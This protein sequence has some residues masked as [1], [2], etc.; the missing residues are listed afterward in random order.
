MNEEKEYLNYV[1]CEYEKQIEDNKVKRQVVM[2]KYSHDNEAMIS[3]LNNIDQRLKSLTHN[4]NKPFFARIDFKNSSTALV[5]KCYI[6]RIGIMNDDNDIVTIDWRAPIASVYYDCQLGNCTY[7]SPEGLIEGELLIKRQYEIENKR[8]IKFYDVDIVSND[9]LLNE[10]LST[11]SDLRLKN[12]IST[13]QKEQNDIIRMPIEKNIVVQGVAGSGKTTV[14]LHRLAYLVYKNRDKINDDQ[15]M[16]ICPN[17]FF[18]KYI[19]NVLPDLDV[20]GIM[21][22]DLLEFANYF[23]GEKINLFNEKDTEI[24]KY[25][26]SMEYKELIDKYILE[27]NDSVLPDKDLEMFGISII[28]KHVINEIYK[29][30]EKETKFI[31]ARVDRTIMFTKKY[32]TENKDDILV[33][34]D[35]IISD[36]YNNNIELSKNLTNIRNEIKS[37][38]RHILKKYF[39]V[40]NQKIST[41]YLKFLN[42]QSF[43]DK[44]LKYEDLPGLLY[45]GYNIL[46]NAKCMKYEHIVI[47]EAQD[48]GM[49]LF[50][51]MKQIFENSTFSIFGDLAQTIYKYRSIESWDNIK[52]V[53]IENDILFLKKSYRTT[54][55]IM[56]KANIINK[57]LGL[58][59]A[60]SVIRHGEEIEIANNNNILSI[61][62]DLSKKYATIGIISKNYEDSKKIY[63]EL[64]ENVNINLIET[65]SLE[66]NDGI[67]SITSDLAKGLEFDAVVINKCDE[68]I[69]NINDEYDMKLLYVSM[70]RALHKLVITYDKKI[71]SLIDNRRVYE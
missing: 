52:K 11:S 1:L 34:I 59:L 26:S 25:K 32:I 31:N 27:L 55:E 22:V 57:Y 51:S 48:Y 39:N 8:L 5:D 41:L 28:S 58:T 37:D 68:D 21:E 71:V 12:I 2:K 54:I 36:K 7:M 18:V 49:L 70:T 65:N 62:K 24:T 14:A 38:C 46:G 10:S 66:Y 64:K 42:Q 23:L 19:S 13:I 47:D 33:K 30:V 45:L 35:K 63:D 44:V 3:N 17:K 43:S 4:I 29:K 50:Y 15:Y 56:E 16:I 40:V 6:G 9:S 60:D 20:D 61:V 53:D 69:F 67:I